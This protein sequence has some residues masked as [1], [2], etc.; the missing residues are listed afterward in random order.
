MTGLEKH[1]KEMSA[2]ECISFE[3]FSF[4]YFLQGHLGA[5][6][7]EVSLHFRYGAALVWLGAGRDVRLTTVDS[8][9]RSLLT[10]M[11]IAVARRG[12]GRT[13]SKLRVRAAPRMP[14]D[15]AMA[16]T[17]ANH[18]AEGPN[19]KEKCTQIGL[20]WHFHDGRKGFF[21]H[22]PGFMTARIRC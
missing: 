18:L 12:L 16:A 8:D 10:H 19:L 17:A 15:N 9:S 13:V 22:Q 2:F 14:G 3:S 6:R 20:N 11:P 4:F 5:S 21:E 7:C 1:S